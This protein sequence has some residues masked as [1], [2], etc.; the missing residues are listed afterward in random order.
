LSKS[1]VGRQIPVRR[2]RV[3]VDARGR[4]L[5]RSIPGD[6]MCKFPVQQDCRLVIATG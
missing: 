3:E 6:A 4:R 1:H 2:E 5:R